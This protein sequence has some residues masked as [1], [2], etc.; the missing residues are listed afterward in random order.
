MPDG[1][2]E[3]IEYL[4]AELWVHLRDY[5]ALKE[6][7]NVAIR[8]RT[9]AREGKFD[10]AEEARHVFMIKVDEY[11]KDHPQSEGS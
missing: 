6:A 2:E 7:M 4:A 8:W 5:N 11:V 10:G 9:L 1:R 3:T